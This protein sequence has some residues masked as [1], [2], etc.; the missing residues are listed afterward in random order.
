[1]G[2]TVVGWPEGR[3]G[4]A[5]PDTALGLCGLEGRA[6]GGADVVAVEAARPTEV[7]PVREAITDPVYHVP[8]IYHRHP[9]GQCMSRH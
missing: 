1:M 6:A 5:I 8:Y 2:G 3:L 4:A 9:S 7:H